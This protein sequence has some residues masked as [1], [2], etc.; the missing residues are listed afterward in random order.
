MFTNAAVQAG[1]TYVLKLHRGDSGFVVFLL[2]CRKWLNHTAVLKRGSRRLYKFLSAPF[3]VD[4]CL[5]CIEWAKSEKRTFL[6][7]AL[8]V[9]YIADP[10]PV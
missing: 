7:Q 3:K 9:R 2:L 1:M 10:K 6:R 8:E 5:E 4:L